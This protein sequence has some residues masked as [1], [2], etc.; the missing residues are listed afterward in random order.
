M[1]RSYLDCANLNPDNSRVERTIRT[2]STVRMNVLF[3][4][5]PAGANTLA[6]LETILQTANLWDLNLHRYIT[7]LLKEVTKLRSLKASSV[8]YSPFLPWNLTSQL[9]QELEAATEKWME[10]SEELENLK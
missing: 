6:T 2:F 4:G 5:S 7:Y 1:F 9:R 3:A 8:D 10:A